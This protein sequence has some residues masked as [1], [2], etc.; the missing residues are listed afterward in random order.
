[1]GAVV[2]EKVERDSAPFIDCNNLAVEQ[3]IDWQTFTGVG[4]TRKL[5]GEEI[6]ATRP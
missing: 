4:D 3:R 2:L 5:G 6:T 1:M